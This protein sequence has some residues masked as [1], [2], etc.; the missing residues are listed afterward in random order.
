MVIRHVDKKEF[1]GLFPKA[2]VRF[3]SPERVKIRTEVLTELKH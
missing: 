3:F 1:Y 2:S